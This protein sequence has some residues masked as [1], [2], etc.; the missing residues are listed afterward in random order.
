MIS[1]VVRGLLNWKKFDKCRRE[2]VWAAKFLLLPK[3]SVF[4]KLTT[5]TLFR[6]DISTGQSQLHFEE[7][8]FV[9]LVLK[10]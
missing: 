4:F 2:E 10:Y 7:S 8:E 9:F 3:I 6:F 1:S 5:L